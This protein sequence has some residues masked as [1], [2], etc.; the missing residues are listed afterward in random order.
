M[1]ILHII[2]TLNPESGGPT[3]SVRILLSFGPIGYT[4]EVVTLDS[5]DAPYLKDLKYPVHALGPQTSTYGYNAKLVPWLRAN[6]DRFDGIVVN[7]LW[8]YC[9]L[10]AWRAIR[11]HKP[12]VVF[13]HGMLDP[14]FKHAFPIKHLKKWFYWLPAE[15]WVLRGAYRVLFTCQAE[16]ELAEKS[17]W[18]HRWRPH[19][20]PYG[21]QSPLGD[22]EGMKEAFFTKCP[23]VRGKRYLLYL[24]RIHRKKGCDLLIDAFVKF[25]AKDP[26]LSLVMAGPDQQ[27]WADELKRPLI[28]AGLTD[29]VLWPGLIRGDDK[30]GA[31]YGCEA[32]ILPSHQENFGIAVAEALACG[33][34]A[35]LADKVNIAPEIQSDGAGYMES[36]TLAGTEA[37]LQ[38]WLE[39][40]PE[41]RAAMSK[42][43]LVS[44]KT[45]YDMRENAKTIIRL[46]EQFSK[47]NPE[48]K[49][50][51]GAR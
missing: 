27:G 45:R 42:Q 3:E 15:Y 39:T 31:F 25:A 26:D 44:F 50:L 38:R 46:F 30:W 5:P 8:Q 18:L 33:K 11:G 47:E 49:T 14:Y 7:G 6:R 10:S 12:Y 22:P 43:A 17:F 24:G 4:G 1:R 48:E 36:D 2:S 34:P 32:F 20:V 37:L 16:K 23:A 41:K 51:Q 9:G 28:A 40:T 13:T 21:A 19:V 29:R 35:L